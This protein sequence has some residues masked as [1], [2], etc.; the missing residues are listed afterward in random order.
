M[1]A[2]ELF[3]KQRAAGYNRF[4][5]TWIPNYRYFLNLLPKLLLPLKEQK[6][7]VVGCGTGNEI[8]PLV[9]VHKNWDITGIDPSPEMID[10]ARQKLQPYSNVKLIE[11]V[12]QNLKDSERYGASTLLL[13]LH[14]LKDD[15]SKLELL[16]QIAQRL[17]PG[18]PL[19]LLDIT[20]DSQQIEGNLNVLRA[21]IPEDVTTEE[22]EQ[23]INRIANEL[24]H[25]SEPRLSELLVQAG[26]T[27][28]LRFFQSAIY[29]GWMTTKAG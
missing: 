17:T 20:G 23:R 4:V 2:V 13:V 18:A 6:L 3:E 11:G 1:S 9:S 28:P 29:M 10:Q 25:V 12:V 8:E 27:S 5:E 14:F 15:G 26:F 22:I 16:Q 19:I 7:L 21:M 24:H